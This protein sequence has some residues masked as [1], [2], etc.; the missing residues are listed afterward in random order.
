MTSPTTFCTK[1]QRPSSAEC[2][3]LVGFKEGVVQPSFQNSAMDG[4]VN[5]RIQATVVLKADNDGSSHKHP[6]IERHLVARF[7]L[8]FV[9]GS[10]VDFKTEHIIRKNMRGNMHGNEITVGKLQA[11]EVIAVVTSLKK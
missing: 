2:R 3:A 7:F 9:L 1:I 4:S 6:T 8:P 5:L 10:D 11:S